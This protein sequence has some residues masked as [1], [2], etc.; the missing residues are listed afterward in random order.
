MGCQNAKIRYYPNGVQ[1]LTVFNYPRFREVER[2]KIDLPDTYDMDGESRGD[3]VRRAKDKIFDIAFLNADLWKY[4]ITFTLDKERIDRYDTE[5]NKKYLVQWLKNQ[6]KRKGLVYLIVPELHKDNAIHYHGFINDCD[7]TFVDSGKT[8]KSGR[9]I[10]NVRDWRLGYTT[11]VELDDNKIAVAK[12]ITKYTTKQLERILGN[13]YYAGGKGLE[14]DVPYE[15]VEL[16]YDVYDVPEVSI[17]NT[18]IK[19]KYMVMGVFSDE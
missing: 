14:R 4:M 9:K 19:V 13:F 6:V 12:Y 5:Q 8:D 10:Y 15:Y 11:A 3:S 17:P 18:D 1:K 7:F 2:E 16:D